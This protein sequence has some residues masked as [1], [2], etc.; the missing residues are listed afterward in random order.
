MAKLTKA[1]KEAVREA[2]AQS[3]A[4]AQD[5]IFDA[6]KRFAM[7]FGVTMLV[8]QILPRVVPAVSEYQS[9]IDFGLAGAGTYFAVTDPG[10]FGDLAVGGA[11][12][13]GV[14]TIDNVANAISD[15]FNAA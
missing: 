8:T 4:A 11:A 14:Q 2:R 7:G 1:Q 9:W 13:G 15:F 5:E 10:P 12:V 6:R 3:R